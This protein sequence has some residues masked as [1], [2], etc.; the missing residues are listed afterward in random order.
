MPTLVSIS[1]IWPSILGLGL[2][3]T[4]HWM[5]W[6]LCRAVIINS[7]HMAFPCAG[8][9]GGVFERMFGYFLSAA[10]AACF[11]LAATMEIQRRRARH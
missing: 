6:E 2:L 7:E 9:L 11:V 4:G 8:P 5:G 1:P 3:V 10:A